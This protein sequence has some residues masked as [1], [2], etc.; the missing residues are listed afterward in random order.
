MQFINI[1]LLINDYK[2]SVQFWKYALKASPDYELEEM[3]YAYFR[4]DSAGIELYKRDKFAA[5]MG[6]PLLARQA[7]ELQAVLVFL[8]DNVDATYEQFVREGLNVVAKPQDRPEWNAR[9]AHVYDPKGYLI[10]FYS[11]LSSEI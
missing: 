5:T 2:E 6:D 10:E 8:V 9:S 7:Q 1:R 3:G 11:P 4:T